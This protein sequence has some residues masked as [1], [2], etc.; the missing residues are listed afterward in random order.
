MK[1]PRIFIPERDL[2]KNVKKLFFER[3]T[4]SKNHEINF[5]SL[6]IEPGARIGYNDKKHYISFD[7]SLKRLRKAGYKR[8]LYPW[9]SFELIISH[10]EGKL[11]ERLDTVT[12][13][14]LE[15]D[16]EWFS[17]AF[18]KKKDKLICYIDPENLRWNKYEERYVTDETLKYGY[19]EE[20]MIGKIPS[21]TWVDLKEFD[22]YFVSLFC[23]RKFKDLPIEMQEKAHIYLPPDGV[24]W[25]VGRGTGTGLYICGHV[26]ERISRGVREKGFTKYL[27][28]DKL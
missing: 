21:Q 9:E 28:P 23:N 22:D 7:K 26:S 5:D 24:L 15:S 8:H 13:N 25:P 6:E 16:G 17:M 18:E 2:E 4:F 14:I 12:K 10:F 27:C 1:I 11:N 19:K 3:S 20:L